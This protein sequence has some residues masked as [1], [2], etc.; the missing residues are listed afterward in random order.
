MHHQSKSCEDIITKQQW[1]YSTVQNTEN[2]Q[3]YTVDYSWQTRTND[4]M[5]WALLQNGISSKTAGAA[6]SGFKGFPVHTGLI[7][8]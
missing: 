5:S 7:L 4:K 3:L 6:D 2:N 8:E 1:L